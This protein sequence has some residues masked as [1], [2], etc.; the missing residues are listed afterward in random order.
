MNSV[1]NDKCQ[2][3]CVYFVFLIQ[4]LFNLRCI[5]YTKLENNQIAICLLNTIFNQFW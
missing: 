5:V 2:F 4:S 3:I 1:Y